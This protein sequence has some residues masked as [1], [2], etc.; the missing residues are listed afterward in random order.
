M[1]IESVVTTF[2]S[3]MNSSNKEETNAPGGEVKKFISASA[4]N[5][6][7]PVYLDSNAKVAKSATA[8]NYATFVGIVVGGKQT[9]GLTLWDS[10]SVGLAAASAADEE[11][12]VALPNSIAYVVANAATSKGA[13]VIGSA[14]SGKVTPG[15]TATQVLGI[16]MEQAVNQNDVIKLFV[17]HL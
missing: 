13:R 10:D 16:A 12:Y 15:T 1:P 4:L 8:A 3:V 11:V 6:G 7:D 5:V 17:Q 9:Y 2:S 14:S